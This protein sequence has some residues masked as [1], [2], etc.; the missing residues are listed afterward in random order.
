MFEAYNSIT[1]KSLEPWTLP[2][3]YAPTDM[4]IF[5]A[6]AQLHGFIF[7]DWVKPWQGEVA[8]TSLLNSKYKNDIHAHK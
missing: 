4:S 8:G 3:L 2:I 6:T 5:I 1:F 7:I